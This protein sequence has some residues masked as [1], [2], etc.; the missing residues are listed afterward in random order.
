MDVLLRGPFFDLLRAGARGNPVQSVHLKRL[1]A[2]VSGVH[3]REFRHQYARARERGRA[4][5]IGSNFRTMVR[6]SALGRW[7]ANE[8]KIG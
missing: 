2:R 6:K 4:R 7:A 5:L 8:P 1:L 3:K